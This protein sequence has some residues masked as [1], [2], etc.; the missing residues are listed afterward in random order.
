M[1]ERE[2]ALVSAGHLKGMR[3]ERGEILREISTKKTVRVLNVMVNREGKKFLQAE[4]NSPSE[5]GGVITKD[6]E[7]FSFLS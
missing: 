4:Y 5:N 7:E 3:V 2:L 1:A 6:I